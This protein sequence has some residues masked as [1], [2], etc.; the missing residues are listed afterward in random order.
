MDDGADA[1]GADDG[2]DEKGNPGTGDEVSLDSEEVTDLV[3]WEPD[4]RER[5]EPKDEEADPVRRCSA[6]VLGKRVWDGVSVLRYIV[7]APAYLC[8]HECRE[9]L[10]QLFQIARII[11]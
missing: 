4:G 9:T 11:R 7:S 10:T 5:D 3:H 1:T 6:S 2:P 8:R